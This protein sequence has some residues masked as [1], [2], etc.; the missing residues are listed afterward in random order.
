MKKDVLDALS[1]RFPSK[2]PSKESLTHPGII[3]HAAGFDVFE[4]T[5]RAFDIAWRKLGIDIHGT[6][7]TENAPRPKVPGG[8]WV[9]NGVRYSDYGVYAT[10]MPLEHAPG[11]PKDDP[12][13]VFN[14]DVSR[15]DFDLDEAVRSLRATNQAFREHFRDR[16]VMYHL[17]YTTL[18]MWPVVTFDW[19][20]FLMAAASDPQKFDELLWQPWSRISRKHF[21]ALAAMEEE[22]VF[23]HDD[24]AMTTG[25]VF[26]PSYFDEY[27]FSR[28]EWIME[29]AVAAGKKIVFVSDGNIDLLLERL[30][31]LPIDGIMFENPATPYERIL[32]TWGEAGRGFIG[33][34][35]TALLTQGTPDEVRAHARETMRRGREYPGFV[36]SSCGQLPGNIP[37]DNILAY[38]E[39]RNEMGCPAEL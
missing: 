13:W 38:F 25:P 16:S 4:D 27:I 32:R 10:G 26:A 19:E 34:I 2:I 8:T 20:P 5:P 3:S 7:P 37:M 18:F 14:Y 35:S 6:L 39:T 21:E 15:H 31:E 24:L 1:G 23:C 11:V 22:V 28:Y 9:E 36:V 17:Y 12:G 33:G 29:P 30:L